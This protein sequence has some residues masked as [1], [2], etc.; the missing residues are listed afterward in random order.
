MN[1]FVSHVRPDLKICW[2]AITRSGLPT[3]RNLRVKKTFL[4]LIPEKTFL[5]TNI[6]YP[7]YPYPGEQSKLVLSSAS[8][9]NCSY[10]FDFSYPLSSVQDS[11]DHAKVDRQ[12]NR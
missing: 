9:F 3:T 5:V 11:L 1:L 6:Y 12:I 2:F 10:S 7:S 4:M 8:F